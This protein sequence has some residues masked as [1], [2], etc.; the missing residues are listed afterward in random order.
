M[1]TVLYKYFGILGSTS[2][3]YRERCLGTTVEVSISI[4]CQLLVSLNMGKYQAR[5]VQ[6]AY[7]LKEFDLKSSKST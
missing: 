6:L 5:S 2:T 7:I 3:T 1:H 4:G